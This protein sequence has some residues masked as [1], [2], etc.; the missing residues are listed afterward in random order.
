[1]TRPV[2]ILDEC[3]FMHGSAGKGQIYSV[4]RN[5]K[6]GMIRYGVRFKLKYVKLVRFNFVLRFALGWGSM[7][8]SKRSVG[9]IRLNDVTEGSSGVDY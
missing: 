9:E 3:A 1:M 8:V 6:S 5:I 7:K 2:A 4:W